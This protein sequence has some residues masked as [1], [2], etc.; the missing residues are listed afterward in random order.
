MKKI[1]LMDVNTWA[2]LIS[3]RLAASIVVILGALESVEA[4]E[5]FCSSGNVTCLIAAI[6]EANTRAGA[7]TINLDPGTYTLTSVDHTNEFG[8]EPSGR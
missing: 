8:G 4:A 3:L 2:S 7:D 6:N 5:F 1:A